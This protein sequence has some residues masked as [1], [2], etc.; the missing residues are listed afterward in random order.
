MDAKVG[1]WVGTPRTGKPVEIQALWL[2]AL[3]IASQ[4][5]PG[6]QKHFERGLKS[7]HDKFWN[8]Q[9]GGLF[10]VIAVNHR[11][12]EN[13]AAI[14]PNQIF[15][16]GGLPFQLLDGARA[17]KVVALVEETLLTPLGLRS[18]APSEPDYQPHYE[19]GVWQR[20]GAYHQGTVWP[21]LIGPFVEARVRVRG[22]TAAAKREARDTF[23][24]PILGTLTKPA[25]V[26]SRKSPMPMRPTPR[27]AV[28]SRLGPWAKPCAWI[29]WCWR[30]NNPKRPYRRKQRCGQRAVET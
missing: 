23:L 21:W 10:D 29:A 30:R 20:D 5:S 9:R 1:E 22:G 8:E 25:W 6:W 27:A 18:L 14:R 19:G 28:T 16:V 17:K 7:F 11:A 12:S 15:A 3:K 26:T 4:F 24:A 2:N 13:D